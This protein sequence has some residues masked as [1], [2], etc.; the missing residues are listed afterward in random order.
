MTRAFIVCV[1]MTGL[2]LTTSLVHAI[3][4]PLT[5]RC[6][7]H[8]ATAV[9]AYP[10]SN[11]ASTMSADARYRAPITSPRLETLDVLS[12]GLSLDVFR[13]GQ[14]W[15][16]LQEQTRKQPEALHVGSMILPSTSG[17]PVKR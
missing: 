12:I 13:Q 11:K 8:P 4:K 7:A 2:L 17:H 9:T 1:S 6:F 14:A 15:Q 5:A 16:A 10:S 3:E